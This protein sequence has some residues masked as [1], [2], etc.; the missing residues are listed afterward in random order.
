V[1]VEA[2]LMQDLRGAAELVA[3]DLRRAGY[4][5][6]A[7]SGVRVEDETVVAN[8]YAAIAPVDAPDAAVT[9]SFATAASA[10][11]TATA[12]DSERFGFRLRGGAIEMQLGA[13]NWQA[14]SDPG[15]LVVTAFQV[16]PQPDDVSLAAFCAEACPT[17]STA[18]PPRQRVRSFAISIA[19]RSALDGGIVR[20]LQTRVRGRNDVVIG[21]C[22]G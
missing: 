18:C 2:R 19:G 9:L 12:D 13:R 22:E 10:A 11:A 15:T 20:S 1:Q 6:A 8:P 4:W 14:L 3:R 7:A 21:S 17:D 5:S 16:E